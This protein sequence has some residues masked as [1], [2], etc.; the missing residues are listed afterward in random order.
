MEIAF[1]IQ[2]G[3]SYFTVVKRL[4]SI[5]ILSL[6]L[7]HF[8]GFYVYFIARLKAIHTEARAALR[9]L[10]KKELTQINLTTKQYEE[11]KEGDDELEWQNKMYD[12]AY[13]ESIDGLIQVYAR[14]D[15]A[16][17]NLLCFIK[18]VINNAAQDSQTIPTALQNFFSLVYVQPPVYCTSHLPDYTKQ[19]TPEYYLINIHPIH[20]HID[21]PPPRT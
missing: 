10:P 15:E 12:I 1:S 8:A 21:S 6:V 18:K 16:E 2:W 14:H 17:D 5:L 7:M 9:R 3:C 13:V 11:A 20:L 19:S 4:F